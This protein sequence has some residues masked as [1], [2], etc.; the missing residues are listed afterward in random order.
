MKYK[1]V[2]AQLDYTMFQKFLDAAVIQKRLSLT[3]RREEETNCLNHDPDL[4]VSDGSAFF[5]G[6]ID[7]NRRSSSSPPL[8]LLQCWATRRSSSSPLH[9]LQCW[10]T[11]N[12]CY[13]SPCCS[14]RSI[15][16]IVGTL[17]GGIAAKSH[18]GSSTS[19]T[20]GEGWNP[21]DGA[22]FLVG[23]C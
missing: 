10:A 7:K 21:E 1:K 23:I 18:P 5:Q 2:Q 16:C 11:S 17:W 13:S 14:C 8:H 3:T 15:K 4:V 22:V 12:T 19:T 20:F 6:T 9:L